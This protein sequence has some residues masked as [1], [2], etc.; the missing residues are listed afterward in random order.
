MKSW[1]FSNKITKFIIKCINWDFI[2]EVLK[3]VVIQCFRLPFVPCFGI[4]GEVWAFLCDPQYDHRCLCLQSC[5]F[6]SSL[7]RCAR[8]RLAEG[9]IRID[10]QR[11]PQWW[12]GNVPRCTVQSGDGHIPVLNGALRDVWRMHCGICKTGLL[13]L[14]FDKSVQIVLRYLQYI[15]ICMLIWHL[16]CILSRQ[17]KNDVSAAWCAHGNC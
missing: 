6:P 3:Y 1:K 11:C 17:S 9:V 10:N 12:R 4:P 2:N 15:Y 13:L 14:L 5:W 7:L 16:F 8:R